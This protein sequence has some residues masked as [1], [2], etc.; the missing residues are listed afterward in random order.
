MFWNDGHE[1]NQYVVSN[2]S[3]RTRFGFQGEAKITND[4]TAG[5]L[6]EIGVRYAGSNSRTQNAD[7]AGG[8]Q[9]NLDIRHSAWFLDSKH[10]GRVWVGKTATATQDITEINLANIITSGTDLSNWNN[11]FF[12]RSGSGGLSAVTWGGLQ[13]RWNNNVG[14]GDRANTVRYIS[15]AYAGF[16]M[17]SS[18]SED[19]KLDTAVRYAG[20]FHGVRLAAGIGYQKQT[21]FNNGDGNAGCANPGARTA[22][23]GTAVQATSNPAISDVNCEAIGMSASVMHVPT[24]IFVTGAYGESKDK[25][26]GRLATVSGF[27]GEVNEKNKHF[28]IQAGIEQ[29]WFAL[30]KTTLY[31]EY[32]NNKSGNSLTGG[33]LTTLANS[34]ALF[35]GLTSGFN[36]RRGI[37]SSEVS[38]WGLG[39][40]QSLE[41]AAADIYLGYRNY[42]ASV[43][44]VSFG[45][46]APR[47]NNGVKDFQ[48]VMTGMIIR[49]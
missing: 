1:S 23:T 42:S 32:I 7:G 16:T 43:D 21:D 41:A 9:N 39:F 6:L 36:A 25:N 18:W 44:T 28:A 48:A 29:K 8:N 13:S 27:G 31:G 10:L 4:L 12:A 26:L 34:D 49:F 2:N 38:V 40:T 37:T 11:G 20:E 3:S 45:A 17:S 24:G 19:D 30:G 46:G 5:Y 14:E 35:S 33:Q 47:A 15:P 22:P